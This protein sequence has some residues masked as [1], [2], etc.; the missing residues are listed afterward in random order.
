QARRSAAAAA[1]AARAAT[2]P[3]AVGGTA[4]IAQ[5][6]AIFVDAYRELNA[7]KLF[8]IVLGLS[9]LVVAAFAA[10][11]IDARGLTI[12]GYRAGA[13]PSTVWI[14][15][16][17][18]YKQLFITLGVSIWLTW[19]ATPLALVST[20][21]TFP[22]L[23]SGGTV[24]LYLSKPIGRLRLFLTK[25][26]AALTFVVLQ[27]LVFSAASFLVLG[28]RGGTWS[29]GVFLAVPVVVVF[30]SYL[31]CVCVLFG[32]ITRS[33]IAAILLTV[34]FWVVL[35][36]V[37]FVEQA[38]LM[39]KLQN[40]AAVERLTKAVADREAR[41]AAFDADGGEA[42]QAS[43]RDTLA[44][45]LDR[46]TT[47]RDAARRDLAESWHGRLLAAKT[48]LPKT[49]ETVG[50]LER[51]MKAA[52]AGPRDD[53]FATADSDPDADAAPRRG[54]FDPRPGPDRRKA[55]LKL[56]EVLAARSVGWVV[57][58]SLAFEAV[59]LGVAAW[60]FCRRDY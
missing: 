13:N 39:V 56:R 27:V 11:G 33:T 31:Y 5:T 42:T 53:R 6:A 2:G 51:W 55:E 18:F 8:W 50:L 34:V 45:L 15:R 46:A 37:H 10:V 22:D 24:D 60:V 3:A 14:E 12:F 29:W 20:A 41:L 32:L 23:V 30:Y 17:F 21:G 16:P 57:G 52:T 49:S 7:K 4:M 9:A 59:V 1:G 43:R 19:A 26:L 25:Y 48:L 47:D 44:K 36:S 54:L 40:E 28:L 38:S 35:F 58:T